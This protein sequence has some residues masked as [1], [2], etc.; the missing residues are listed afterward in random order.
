MK[1]VSLALGSA[2]SPSHH[3]RK[4][5]IH[6]ETFETQLIFHCLIP[7]NTAIKSIKIP[8][9]L[10]ESHITT[11][12]RGHANQPIYR[13]RHKSQLLQNL[14]NG[15]AIRMRVMLITWFGF[16]EASSHGGPG[17]KPGGPMRG[18]PR[19]GVSGAGQIRSTGWA[20]GPGGGE[21]SAAGGKFWPV[22]PTRPSQRSATIHDAQ[23][24]KRQHIIVWL[25]ASQ[26]FPLIHHCLAIKPA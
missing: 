10:K 4:T 6:C 12:V 3:R 2:P 21:G 11:A 24:E 13:W 17:V 14:I 16:G 19:M 23:P 18:K 22:G 7:L 20:A 9:A 25:C 8:P 5:A 26:M 1:G 15:N